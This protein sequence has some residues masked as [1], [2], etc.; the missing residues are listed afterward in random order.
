M[1]KEF[2][3]EKLNLRIEK[4]ASVSRALSVVSSTSAILLSFV[5]LVIIIT[6]LGLSPVKGLTSF[7]S[8]AFGSLNAI[9]EGLVKAT[10]LI[11]VGV[12]ISIAFQSNV[13]NIGAEGQIT[14]GAIAATAIGISV[15]GPALLVIFAIL[16]GSFLLGGVWGGIAGFLKAKFG[17]N[18]IIVTIMMNYIAITALGYF[19]RGPLSTPDPWPR[20]P[21]ILGGATFPKL[22]SGMRLHIG[23]LIAVAVG[24]IGYIFLFRTSWGFQ[25]RT[26]GSNPEVA[27]N[28]GMSVRR[29][30]T[31]AMFISGGIAGLAGAGLVVG[32]HH[33]LMDNIASG[34]GYLGIPVALIA[35]LRPTGAILI[36]I[37]FGILIVGI[38]G[39]F[40]VLNLPVQGVTMFVGLVM[41]SVLIANFLVEY[42]VWVE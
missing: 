12:A 22:I 2:L 4:R 6:V 16:V 7:F 3:E 23:F 35:K 24:I 38:H 39:T 40:R 18:E 28:M 20:S 37:L 9:S 29:Q 8:A 27:T 25:L 1:F 36:G 13:I 10:P 19:V 26:V 15:A 5:I 31:L 34:Y 30:I 21:D 11:L 33:Y 14:L 17:V 41:L 42:R 32:L